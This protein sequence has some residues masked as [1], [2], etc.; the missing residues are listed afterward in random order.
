MH[1][2]PDRMTKNTRSR[3]LL[4]LALSSTT[5]T[6]LPSCLGFVIAP[7][8]T[9][10]PLSATASS[11]DAD[12]SPI[13]PQVWSTGYSAK[14]DL[15]EALQEATELAMDGL[16]QPPT[17]TC[18]SSDDHDDASASASVSISLAVVSISSL[19]DGQSSPS[20]VVPTVL[21][22]ASTYGTGIQHLLGCTTGGIISSKPNKHYGNGAPTAC[23][24]IESEGIPGVSVVLAILPDV[25]L[26]VSSLHVTSRCVL[27]C[28]LID[29][30]TQP[31][32]PPSNY[33]YTITAFHSCQQQT[34]H[35]LGDD[36]PD[37]VGRVDPR[38][39]KRA[40]GLSGFAQD[41]GDSA[42]NKPSFFLVPAPS[43]Q[44]EL[45]D[46]LQGLAYNFPQSTTFGGI[47][48]TV[49]SLSRARL[50]RYDA[51]DSQ[52]TATT[53]ADGCVGVAMVGDLEVK[54][55]VAQGTKPV[56]GIYRVV[57]GNDST[58]NAIVLDEA[59]TQEANEFEDAIDDDDNDDDDDEGNSQDRNAIMAAAYAKAAIPKPPL[60]E[61][62][63]VMRTLSD[64]DQAF[65]RK[66][67][68]VGLE[69]GGS[70][71]RTPNELA[72]LADGKGHRFTVYQVA[73]AGMKDGSVTLPLG[74]SNV[75]P[76]TRLR[77]FVR[78]SDFSKKEVQAL[79]TG[80]KKATLEETMARMA[81]DDADDGSA[82]TKHFE[83]AMCMLMSTLD[84]GSKFFG[85]RYETNA[86]SQFA[87]SVP[88]IGG[89]FANGVLGRLDQSSAGEFDVMVHGSA[90]TYVLLGSA[91]RRPVYIASQA[92][93]V[94]VEKEEDDDSNYDDAEDAS[95]PPTFV[96]DGTAP[97]AP[98]GELILK[99]RE[100][101][102]GRAMSVATV[103][104]SV[105][106]NMATPSSTLEMYLWEKETQV[107]C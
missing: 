11:D 45:D 42:Q 12:T 74:V 8:H 92:K 91:S 55:M 64:D 2:H 72:R 76:G 54:T 48:S 22:S 31:L 39:W 84:R 81:S 9:R 60:A 62:N 13:A 29:R 6:S 97:R 56:G 100:V 67:I 16:P 65:M 21:S 61:C 41:D 105:A 88:C 50:F 38:E 28:M 94:A 46:F 30:L 51:H 7:S 24:G 83:P 59:A 4:V 73:S 15:L 32:Y 10:R 90:A 95:A 5:L 57:T 27:L 53:L 63:F 44:N 70:L 75:E 58:V 26:K 68:L 93:K 34:F 19:Y 106:E 96:Q 85:S 40:V 1:M 79:W 104:W 23:T 80:Y 107:R 78:E 71:G 77:F 35:V 20:V 37:D 43:F 25:Q 17:S 82:E 18:T 33:M 89:F 36:V 3:M 47:A 101:H 103:E 102:S 14:N 98:N 49:S 86:I 52:S 66:A 87:P 69:R 99:R